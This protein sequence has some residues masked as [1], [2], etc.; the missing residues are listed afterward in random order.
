VIITECHGTTW[1]RHCTIGRVACAILLVTAA[2]CT[3]PPA[4]VYAT[5]E[6]ID[7]GSVTYT[8]HDAEWVTELP[9]GAD[10]PRAPKQRF[11]IVH[12]AVN[13]AGHA[14]VTPP[15]LHVVDAA[16]VEHIELAEGQGVPS[17]LGVLRNVKPGESIQGRVLFD[18]PP[19]AYNLK[20]TD[21]AEP[22]NEKTALVK[23][24]EAKAHMESPLLNAPKEN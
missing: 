17:W 15:L 22:E 6:R 8:V 10:K 13:N 21:G 7:V 14:E 4:K 11:L 20:V 1:A 3:Q 23:L 24:P 18:V 19:G 2:G 16:N 5:G 9:T 12:L